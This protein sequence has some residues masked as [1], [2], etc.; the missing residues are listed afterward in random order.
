MGMSGLVKL[1]LRLLR[2]GTL[3]NVVITQSSGI[4]SLDHET[5][6]AAQS[7][8]PY[9]PFPPEIVQQELVVELPIHFR[10]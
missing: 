10:S 5:L 6:N 7:Q 3:G 9:P 2:D 8:S 1:R 4:E